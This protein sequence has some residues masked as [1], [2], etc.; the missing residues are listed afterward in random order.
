MDTTTDGEQM[1]QD[2]RD[3]L[4]HKLLFRYDPLSRRI[5]VGSRGTFHII[6][7][8]DYRPPSPPQLDFSSEKSQ[9]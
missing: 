9:V 5:Q 8:D 4:H 1:W 3:P 6:D 2:I 7:L